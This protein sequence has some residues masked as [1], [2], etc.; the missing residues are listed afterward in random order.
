MQGVV[1]DTAGKNNL[2]VAPLTFTRV[3]YPLVTGTSFSILKPPALLA[4]QT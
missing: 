4:T 2:A 1:T 3:A